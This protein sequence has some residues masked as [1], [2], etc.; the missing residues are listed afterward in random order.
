MTAGLARAQV[1]HDAILAAKDEKNLEEVMRLLKCA[2]D[3]V[4]WSWALYKRVD[5]LTVILSTIAT[6]PGR[7]SLSN[8]VHDI[9]AKFDSDW[10]LTREKLEQRWWTERPPP[11]SDTV[12]LAFKDATAKYKSFGEEDDWGIEEVEVGRDEPFIDAF[13]RFVVRANK[14]HRHPFLPAVNLDVVLP[15]VNVPGQNEQT[16]IYDTDAFSVRSVIARTGA[17]T[18]QSYTVQYIRNDDNNLEIRSTC[19]IYSV[20][21]WE[22]IPPAWFPPAPPTWI[23]PIP[24]VSYERAS[25]PADRTSRPGPTP[26]VYKKVPL[27]NYSGNGRDILPSITTPPLVASHIYVPVHTWSYTPTTYAVND[28]KVD[29]VLPS[30]K[31]VPPLS[32]PQVRALLGRVIQYSPDPLREPEQEASGQAKKAKKVKSRSS[33]QGLTRFITAAWGY[34]PATQWLYC[35]DPRGILLQNFVLDLSAPQEH[36][37]NPK[38]DSGDPFATD[39]RCACWVGVTSIAED[40]RMREEEERKA[41]SKTAEDTTQ[42]FD[43]IGSPPQND[44]EEANDKDDK[45]TVDGDK[46]KADIEEDAITRINRIST[47]LNESRARRVFEVIAPTDALLLGDVQLSKRD[48]DFDVVLT[49]LKPGI[50]HSVVHATENCRDIE[51]FWTQAGHVD[52]NNLVNVPFDDRRNEDW[53]AYEDTWEPVGSFSVDSGVSGAIMRSTLE[54][55]ILVNDDMDSESALETFMDKILL[56]GEGENDMLA[57]PGGVVFAGDDGGYQVAARKD[58]HV[59]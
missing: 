57:V 16:N 22:R 49:G 11:T 29:Y 17:P 52:Y 35:M 42:E 25:L 26:T 56:D 30:D 31:L 20:G 1:L 32:E 44:D 28:S 24:P 27:L 47:K 3:E 7:M 36:I 19:T 4:V 34:D 37:R 46:V 58:A 40:R 5:L 51:L 21:P 45:G 2:R 15:K 43:K 50:W 9:R 33:V 54:S 48:C 12:L 53:N 10:K 13:V 59:G 23:A 55:E 18:V 41:A 6:F 14:K 8:L 39:L 38:H